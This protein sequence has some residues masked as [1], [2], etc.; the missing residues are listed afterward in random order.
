[1]AGDIGGG[2]SPDARP[3][4]GPAKSSLRDLYYSTAVSVAVA[5]A[6][7]AVGLTASGW[8]AVVG[9]ILLALALVYLLHI[10]YAVVGAAAL[11]L[12]LGNHI[13]RA[14]ARFHKGQQHVQIR[15]PLAAPRA[16][17][18]SDDPVFSALFDALNSE[19]APD[20][21]CPSMTEGLRQIRYNVYG[22]DPDRLIEACRSAARGF[23]LPPGA[24]L[25]RPDSRRT[26]ER[27]D[28]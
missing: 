3:L 1:M 5:G 25:W 27:L 23:N 18:A 15:V 19:L 12:W 20:G 2:S 9:F 7:L 17:P 28:L 11:S 8:V 21:E 13:D 26:G 16:D 4:R 14:N 22:G 10:V 24:H 6:G